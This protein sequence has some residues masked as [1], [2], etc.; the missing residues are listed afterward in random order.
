MSRIQRPAEVT[1]AWVWSVGEQYGCYGFNVGVIIY[2]FNL[3]I[4]PKMSYGVL[5]CDSVMLQNYMLMILK[6]KHFVI[7]K[8]HYLCQTLSVVY[9]IIESTGEENEA[10][11]AWKRE[12][13]IGVE[14]CN[15]N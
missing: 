7:K 10:S 9:Q 2:G 13:G 6:Q 8:G 3:N 4:S 15:F 11:R 14:G 12:S 5:E 1:P